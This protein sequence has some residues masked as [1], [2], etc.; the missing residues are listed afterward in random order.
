MT[1]CILPAPAVGVVLASV[2]GRTLSGAITTEE[3]K[4]KYDY[5]S[6][7]TQMCLYNYA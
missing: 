1:M 2:T 6:I 5:F 7:C 4:N 3:P